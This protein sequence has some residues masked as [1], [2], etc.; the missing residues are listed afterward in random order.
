MAHD[1]SMPLLAEQAPACGRSLAEQMR[2]KCGLGL[3]PS[4]E[5]TPDRRQTEAD[6]FNPWVA[7]HPYSYMEKG[8]SEADRVIRAAHG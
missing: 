5:S 8:E 1:S 2:M 3:S 4:T 7:S 6:E